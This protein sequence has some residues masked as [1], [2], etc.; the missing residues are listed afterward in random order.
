MNRPLIIVEALVRSALE[1]DR[2][3][4]DEP[5]LREGRDAVR[6]TPCAASSGGWRTGDAAG[7][8]L[9]ALPGPGRAV[10]FLHRHRPVDPGPRRA[11]VVKRDAGGPAG[12]VTRPHPSAALRRARRR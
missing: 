4:L 1:R 7:L 8:V 3:D 6:R 2:V 5:W 12:C 9:A 10:R 11:V